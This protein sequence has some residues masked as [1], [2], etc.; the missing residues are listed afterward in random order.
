MIKVEPLIGDALVKALPDVAR[1]RIGVFREWPYLY[2][3]SPTYEA[4]YLQSYRN[5]ARAIVVGASV[6]GQMVGVSTGTPLV[7]HVDNLSAAFA[8]LP[9]D[10]EDVFYCAESVLLKRYRGR[11]IGHQFFDLREAHARA[12]G[13]KIS[14]FCAVVRPPDHPARPPD[15]RPL[16][17]FWRARGYAPLKGAL[18][19]FDWQDVGDRAETSKSLQIWLRAL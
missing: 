8:G 7:E 3:G 9:V 6:N 5:S 19:T 4:N 18:A 16:D 2:D 1:L 12:L 17:P 11:G 15:Y 10:P 13:F 14:C